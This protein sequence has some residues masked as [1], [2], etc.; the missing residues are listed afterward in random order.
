M[1]GPDGDEMVAC[2]RACGSIAV[3]ALQMQ[4][5]LQLEGELL[6]MLGIFQM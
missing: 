1:G 3:V 5:I 6:S 2:G 4:R